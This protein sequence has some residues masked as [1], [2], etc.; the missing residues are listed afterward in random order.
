[1]AFAEKTL[2]VVNYA[3]LETFLAR[4]VDI[5]A[6]AVA[7]RTDNNI[8]AAVPAFHAKGIKVMGWRWPSVL[9]D[10]CMN[11]AA[12][13]VALFKQGLDGYYVDPESHAKP[14]LNWNQ[15]G[16]DGIAEEFCE[17][18]AQAAND[19]GGVFGFTGHFNGLMV[20]DKMPWKV[21]F[22]HSTVH[23]PQS[24]WRY[25]GGVI[26]HGLPA[27]NYERGIKAWLKAGA[28]RD[29]LQPMAGSLSYVTP[30]EIRAHA[31]AATRANIGSLHFYA[32]GPGVKST[33][34]DAIRAL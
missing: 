2:W 29:Y 8:R 13:A 18:V 1:M 5:G 28:S 19:T 12:K 20:E 24:Y 21:F 33:V 10:P 31:E 32:H 9:R 16:L 25:E 22:K 3:D 26:G 14:H 11:E 27:D 6:T 17:T 4:A 23:L 7:I 30:A 34:W 15:R